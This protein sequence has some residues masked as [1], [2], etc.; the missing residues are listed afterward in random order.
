MRASKIG[1]L[2][3]ILGFGGVVETAW[4]VENRLDVGP[5]GCRTLGVNFGPSFSFEEQQ[6]FPVAAGTA[7]QVRNSF[8]RVQ[9]QKGEPGQVQVLLRKVVFRRTEEEARAFAQNIKL[10]GAGEGKTLRL[11]TNRDELEQGRE[12]NRVGFETHLEITVPPD[13]AVDVENEHGEVDV[14]DAARVDVK[15][16]FES[17]RVERAAGPVQ[18]EARHGD[19]EVAEVGGELTVSNRHGRVGVRTVKGTV[20]VDSEHGDV[21]VSDVGAAVIGAA[22]GEVDAQNVHGKLEV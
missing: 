19:V 11:S 10:S 22:H 21:S 20:R 4:F 6:R 8:G 3:L 15:S 9:V 16:S 13:T 12:R 17:V 18:I 14:S 7:V 5:S 1:L 2:L